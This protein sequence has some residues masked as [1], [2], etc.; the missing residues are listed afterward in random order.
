[1]V[2]YVVGDVEKRRSATSS[3]DVL[4]DRYQIYQQALLNWV[5][6]EFCANGNPVMAVNSELATRSGKYTDNCSRIWLQFCI[7]P[8][9]FRSTSWVA[10]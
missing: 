7:R 10:M 4:G 5:C 6:K 1:M 9:H 2:S 3:E 8:V